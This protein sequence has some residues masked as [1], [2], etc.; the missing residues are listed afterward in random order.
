M[1]PLWAFTFAWFVE[2][3]AGA[4]GITTALLALGIFCLPPVDQCGVEGYFVGADIF[5]DLVGTKLKNWI[6]A[7][8]VKLIHAGTPCSTYSTARRYDGGPEPLR[9][10]E[11]LHGLAGLSPALLARVQEGTRCVVITAELFTAVAAKGGAWSLENPLY[12]MMWLEPVIIALQL[13]C[14]AIKIVIHMCGYGSDFWKP[15]LFLSSAKELAPLARLCDADVRPHSHLPLS[16]RTWDDAQQ[17]FVYVTQAA[18]VY[19]QALC[20]AYAQRLILRLAPPL[21]RPDQDALLTHLQTGALTAPAASLDDGPLAPFFALTTPPQ[22][23]KRPVGTPLRH[24][25][26]RQATTALAAVGAGYQLKRTALPPLLPTEMEPGQV[27]ATALTLKHPLLQPPE[28]TSDVEILLHLFH[29]EGIGVNAR[30][31]EALAHWSERATVLL[32]QSVALIN[33]IQDPHLRAL[34]GGSLQGPVAQLDLGKFVHFALWDEMCRAAALVDAGYVEEF[35]EGLTIVGPV[36]RSGVWPAL[37]GPPEP[38]LQEI[39]DRAWDV[40]AQIINRVKCR[41][42]NEH[43]VKLWEATLADVEAGFALGPWRSIEEVDACVGAAD[44]LCTERVAIIQKGKM[45]AIDSATES[46]INPATRVTEKLGL[47]STD[48]NVEVIRRL[49][50]LKGPGLSGELAAWVVD[51]RHAY[52]QVGVAPAHRK[53]AVVTLFDP[54]TK[55]VAFVVMI[56]HSFGWTSAV[57]NYNRR[58]LSIDL[59]LRRLFFVN[60]AFFFDDKFAFEFKEL[61]DTSFECTEQLHSWLGVHLAADKTQRDTSPR[62]LGIRYDLPNF[63]L[64]V[65]EER[66][67]DLVAEIREILRLRTLAPGAAGKLKG[68]LSFAASQFWGKIGRAF[69]RALAERQYLRSTVTAL[70]PPLV[71]S[72]KQWLLILHEGRPRSLDLVADQTADVVIFTD[73]YFPDWRKGDVAPG[74]VGGVIFSRRWTRPAHYTYEVPEALMAKWLP[75]KNQI[76]MIE[77]LGVVMAFEFWHELVRNSSVLLFVDSE[78]VQG[79][80]VK[81]YSH[82]E[83]MCELTGVFWALV[84]ELNALVYIDRVPTDGNVADG[85]SRNTM[86]TLTNL[87]S[88]RSKTWFPRCLHYLGPG[89]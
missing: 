54:Y 75:R 50:S 46:L 78:P 87:G 60:S 24:I 68:K 11:Q 86:Q 34:Y 25:M 14:Q 16:G 5:Q 84:D 80:L 51:E 13:I 53:Y 30:R 18:Q 48:G 47:A 57:Y 45:R 74:R 12:S 15:T 20:E 43:S 4:A 27:I 70:T 66:K 21:Q 73:G 19:P 52:R 42:P 9:S 63:V 29:T 33:A 49:R 71:A 82:F 81:G 1:P 67:A 76:V 41:G 35:R 17:R 88:I 85:P 23:R 89:E 64:E 40:R 31:K 79:A 77:L 56:G 6:D 38:P 55:V 37:D 69:L 26:H 32:P 65:V 44:W 61:V 3:F 7:G 36:A 62:I 22:E 83:D 28:L 10:P 59:I 8:I 39:H 58:S 2:I 72:L